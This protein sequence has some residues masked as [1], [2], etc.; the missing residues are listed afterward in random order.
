[1]LEHNITLTLAEFYQRSESD[2]FAN[3][4]CL[5]RCFLCLY[6]PC[7]NA[8][9][10]CLHTNIKIK[11]TYSGSNT[12]VKVQF[13]KRKNKLNSILVLQIQKHQRHHYHSL[14]CFLKRELHITLHIWK[15]K[16]GWHL[17]FPPSFLQTLWTIYDV[18]TGSSSPIGKSSLLQ[19]S[20]LIIIIITLL[21][22]S[23]Q[24]LQKIFIFLTMW[25]SMYRSG[26]AFSL[27]FL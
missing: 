26:M 19:P 4:A 6:V 21:L 10:S 16:T 7:W 9:I 20:S 5:L 1:M 27:L 18:R 11:I 25:I 22:H 13:C 17:A 12:K 14:S 24:E 23:Q 2:S 3:D 8:H 15:L